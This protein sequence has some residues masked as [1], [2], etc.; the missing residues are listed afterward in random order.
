[1]NTNRLLLC[2]LLA[3]AG[4][5]LLSMLTGCSMSAPAAASAGAAT[6]AGILE[7]GRGALD[8]L[9]QHQLLSPEQAKTLQTGMDHATGWASAAN[10]LF[11][12]FANSIAHLRETW[13][14]TAP[15]IAELK[16]QA[17]QATQ[18]AAH[19]DSTAQSAVAAAGTAQDVA[20]GSG[21]AVLLG[22]AGLVGHSK[23]KG[24]VRKVGGA[25]AATGAAAAVVFGLSLLFV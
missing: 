11:G 2:I 4:A 14:S 1:M 7:F 22:G 25:V 3:F 23:G 24:A 9:N 5:V 17:L 8:I 12:L 16:A 6:G 20:M 15:Q 18:L 19:A 13:T 21:G 10:D